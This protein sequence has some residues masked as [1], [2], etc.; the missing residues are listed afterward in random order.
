MPA[1][2]KKQHYVPKFYLKL[3]ANR[4][5]KFYAFD[6]KNTSL[7]PSPVFYESQCYIPF[8]YGE[9]GVIEEKLSNKEGEW[10]TAVK[11]ILMGDELEESDLSLIKE[12]IIYQRLRTNYSYSHA[13]QAQGTML[14]E[15]AEILYRNKNWMFDDGI[16]KLCEEKA[17]NRI[18]PALNIS[19]ASEMLKYVEDL[20]VQIVHY[21]TPNKLVTSDAPVTTL[22]AF[23]KVQG[24]GYECA[25]AVFIMPLTP[26]YLVIMYDSLFYSKK[27]MHIY[28]ESTDEKEVETVNKYVLIGAER[29]VFSADKASFDLIG[30][31]IL[32]NRAK[33]IERNKAY[34]LGPKESGKRLMVSPAIGT[35]Y[36]YELPYTKLTRESRRI[37]FFCREPFPRHFSEAWARKLKEKYM[38]LSKF[39]RI[40]RDTDAEEKKLANG[41]IRIG[42]R[43]METLAQGYWRQKDNFID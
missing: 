37:P 20:T 18:T 1:I 42:C 2:K 32:G 8:F 21:T 22:N 28:C 34:F 7:I 29:M 41:D 33:E 40:N 23:T 17:K 25:G 14:R 31:E 39:Q 43:R 3:F 30:E 36:Y 27:E 24:F 13:L 16:S 4:D 9:D 19:L 11:K 5:K 6:F 10:A 15:C 26:E 12:F 38:I 35:N